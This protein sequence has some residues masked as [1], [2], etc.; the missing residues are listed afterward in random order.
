MNFMVTSFLGF[1]L[2]SLLAISLQIFFFTPTYPHNL[3]FPSPPVTFPTNNHL[4]KVAKLGEGMLLYPE[5]VCVD[6]KGMLYTATRDGWIKRM[7]SNGS[8]ENWRKFNTD[9][10]LG[11]TITAA[12]DLIVCDCI[13]GLLKVN[14]DG[15]S[16]LASEF[17]GTKLRFADDVIEA[18][19]G[20]LYF[21]VASTKYG[22]HD[23]YLDALEAKPYGQLLKYDPLTKE[24]SLVLDNLGFANGVA[25]SKDQDYLI[26]CESWKFRCLKY[27][28]KSE[29]RGKTEIFIDNLPGAPDN[30][31]LAPDGSY[32]IA[33]IQIYSSKL[34]FV[35]S[36]SAIRH[37]IITFPRLINLVN[38]ATTR[39]TVVNVGEDGKIIKMLGDQDGKVMS[40]VTSAVEFEDNLYLGSLN[41][42]FIGKLPL[43]TT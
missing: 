29:I 11:L 32:W 42:H 2:A 30:I 20:T 6:N 26:V 24:V 28:L 27:W 23:W 17:N 15:V 39:A 18:S 38:P 5:D 22:L 14:E 4:Q 40:F 19:D 3:Q 21:S 33:L 1:V 37:L 25:L 41:T 9:T 35:H 12:N 13:E 7:H 31:N 34:K 43:K 16:V 36:S 10:L 8:W